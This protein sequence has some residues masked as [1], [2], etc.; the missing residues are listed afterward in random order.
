MCNKNTSTLTNIPIELVEHIATF[1]EVKDLCNLRLVCRILVTSI[2][3]TYAAKVFHRLPIFINSEDSLDRAFAIVRHAVFG[4]AICKVSLYIEEF[5]NSRS[6]KGNSKIVDF[7]KKGLKDSDT[8]DDM[9]SGKGRKEDTS[10]EN[11]SKVEKARHTRLTA[12]LGRL[13]EFKNLQEVQLAT[14]SDA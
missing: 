3:R 11:A 9:S 12:I 8:E 10:S 5:D 13:K 7:D 1:L 6:S 4:K 2:D 14:L